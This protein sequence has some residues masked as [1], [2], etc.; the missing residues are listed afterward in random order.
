MK[1]NTL[2]TGF[3]ILF[4]GTLFSC[5]KFLDNPPFSEISESQ[6]SDK[7]KMA[8][9]LLTGCYNGLQ[10]AQHAEWAVTELRSDNARIYSRSS[11]TAIFN[12]IF[13]LDV[14]SPNSLDAF[15]T[16]YWIQNYK[17][18]G[19]CN[20]TIAHTKEVTDA[21][22]KL[23]MD[24]EARFIRAYHYFN[25]VR[26][27]GGVPLVTDPTTFDD[28]EN[29]RYKKRNSVAEVL[30]FVES[31]LEDIIATNALPNQYTDANKGRVTDLAAKAMLAKVYM[32]HYTPGSGNY[33]QA[34]TLLK[35]VITDGGNPQA[36]TDLVPYKDIFS[37]NNEMNKEIIFTVRYMSGNKGLGAP[38]ANEYAPASSGSAVINGQGQSYNYP[39]NSVL[40]AFESNDVRKDVTLAEG[41]TKPNGEYIS[42]DGTGTYASSRYIKKFLSP[43]TII[44][45]A[46]NDFPVIRMGDVLLLY[47]EAVN[48]MQGVTAEALNYYNMIR[49]R[50]GLTAKT[51]VQ[52]ANSYV[53]RDLI[54]KERRVELAFENQ[55]WYDLLR[56]GNVSQ[57]INSTFSAEGIYV[58]GHYSP[59]F[60]P[61]AELLPIPSIVI[62]INP[63]IPQNIGY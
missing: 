37:I 48:E 63:S 53:F 31:E 47:C 62:D 29:A 45:D 36:Y 22:L 2:A 39:T 59:N 13:L 56:W 46:E 51:N 33:G 7:N 58:A 50:A 41:Y 34:I 14:G 57:F 12:S 44:N 1:K 19:R 52:V 17:N 20:N 21:A 4:L 38:F 9:L 43:V 10:K 3:L 35:D 49:L 27:Y 61:A 16:D 40:S 18:I 6:F 42:D 55:R 15:V 32:H 11:S 28:V 23:R 26:L 8:D 30:A 5:K 25:L 60:T 54:R 24:G